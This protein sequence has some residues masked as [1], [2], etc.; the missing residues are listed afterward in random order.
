MGKKDKK[1]KFKTLQELYPPSE[2]SCKICKSY[3]VRSGWWTVEEAF[4]AINA[5][6]GHR[7]MLEVAPEFR[8]TI[9]RV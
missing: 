7:M 4:K 5:G 9:P 2:P 1:N 6:Y 8:R 3:C